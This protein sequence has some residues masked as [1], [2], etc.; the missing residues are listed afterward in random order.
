[1]LAAAAT[2]AARRA[3]ECPRAEPSR[4]NG[5]ATVRAARAALPGSA[6]LP[7]R[8]HV[9]RRAV[10]RARGPTARRAR[11]GG[12]GLRPG[13][14]R[15][16]AGVLTGDRRVRSA[17]PA[18]TVDPGAVTG[19]RPQAEVAP[20]TGRRGRRGRDRRPGRRPPDPRLRPAERAV[21]APR[22]AGRDRFRVGIDGLRIG[23][24]RARG[25]PIGGR[26]RVGPPNPARP[27]ARRIVAH[28]SAM[29]PIGAG[30]ATEVRSAGRPIG[31]RHVES[32]SGSAS[33][34]SP[35]GTRAPG[36]TAALGRGRCQAGDGAA[37]RDGGPVRFASQ[38]RPAMSPVDR[39]PRRPR[40]PGGSEATGRRNGTTASSRCGGVGPPRR[41]PAE[42]RR[43]VPGAVPAVL[44]VFRRLPPEAGPGRCRPTWP[45]RSARRP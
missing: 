34:R 5:G 35:R 31:G 22:A 23:A 8:L 11:P 43:R 9:V 24:R 40:R 13:V 38:A 12:I 27:A 25:H 41:G 16:L 32:R 6:A 3:G 4:R 42:G 29:G 33:P 26:G 45:P 20:T 19:R 37:W 30:R 36:G 44:S 1:M 7:G 28:R 10:H 15:T 17:G 39:H 21:R 18:A 14:P 2:V